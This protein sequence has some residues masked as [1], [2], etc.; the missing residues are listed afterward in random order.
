MLINLCN[1]LHYE[2]KSVHIV[3]EIIL[4][5]KTWSSPIFPDIVSNENLWNNFP[6][7]LDLLTSKTKEFSFFVF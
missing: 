2:P 7:I 3:L 1:L 5:G 4:H 6:E